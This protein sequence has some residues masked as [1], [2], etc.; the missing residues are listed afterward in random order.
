MTAVMGLPEALIED[1]ATLVAWFSLLRLDGTVV[2][3]NRTFDVE[4][5][6][7]SPASPRLVLFRRCPKPSASSS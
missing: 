4:P 6:N 1:T 3:S 2:L 7:M 5:G